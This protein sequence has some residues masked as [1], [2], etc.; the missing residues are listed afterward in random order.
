MNIDEKTD[1]ILK[2]VIDEKGQLKPRFSGIGRF[3][4]RRKKGK[5]IPYNEHEKIILNYF[6]TNIDSNVY[7]AKDTMPMELWALL[8]GQYARRHSTARDRLLMLFEAVY[9][10]NPEKVLS[11]EELAKTIKTKGEIS[12]IMQE[13]LK[14]AGKFIDQY[15]VKYG[16]ASLRD[17]S[18]V[19]TCC[20]GV[21]ERATKYVEGPREGAYQ[22]QSTRALLFGELN[23]G[24]P[25]EI[26]GTY[27]ED[28]LI[29]L[30]KEQL[31]LN[32]KVYKKLIPYIEEKYGYLRER[33]EDALKKVLGERDKIRGQVM[34]WIADNRWEGVIKS[35]A[36]DVARSLLPQNM[37]TSLGITLNAR[38]FQDQLTEWQSSPLIEV[39]VLGRAAQIESMKINPTL[40]KYGNKSEYRTQLPDKRRES[41]NEFIKIMDEQFEYKHYDVK[42]TLLHA[43]EDLEDWVLASILFNASDSKKSLKEIKDIMH[44]L[45]FEDRR[46][47]AERE[48]KGKPSYEINP[49]T[50]EIGAVI[51]ERIY[52][53]GAY[54]DLQRQRGDLQ[55]AAP[56]TVIGYNMP[57]EIR[58][59]GLE[60]EFIDIMNKTKAL[61]EKFKN[62]GYE[63]ASEYVTVMANV[64]R[65]VTTANPRQEFYEAQLRTQPAGIDSYRTIKIMETEQVLELMPA[66]KELVDY[67]STPKYPLGRLP[68]LM[69]EIVKEEIPYR[70]ALKEFFSRK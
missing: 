24:V 35:K 55:Q 11:V 26:Q 17:S 61:N 30:N 56:Y 33:A 66:F 10:N 25:Y 12:E 70:R 18:V 46:K 39:R 41:Y 60:E 38:R 27:L 1:Q 40:M 43:T 45:S 32:D 28:E 4:I 29:S 20:E 44:N 68:E 22:Q 49:F 52:D 37:T 42:S 31:S 21:S 63:Y 5:E 64:I 15:G 3:R 2:E 51:F 48:L 6:F 16:H 47:I 7:C 23:L 59:I 65:H 50:I 36:F 8:M 13:H 9:M 14:T 19:R 62:E 53:I 58:E 34:P 69:R 54:R 67:D 57:E